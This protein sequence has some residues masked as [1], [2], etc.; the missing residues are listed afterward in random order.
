MTERPRAARSSVTTAVVV[1]ACVAV[2]YLL[3]L[4]TTFK[5]GRDQGIYA[6]VADAVLR[7]GA[8]YLDAWDFKPPAVYFA[9]ALAEGVFGPSQAA[10]RVL[11]ALALVSLVPA[12]AILSRRHLGTVGDRQAQLDVVSGPGQQ[13]GQ[14]R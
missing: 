13:R 9:Y 2:V 1:L 4:L 5:Y 10:V 11:E 6:V 3:L 7:G 14:R 8:P 12:F